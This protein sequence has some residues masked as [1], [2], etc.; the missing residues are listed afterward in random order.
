MRLPATNMKDN[1]KIGYV[2]SGGPSPTLGCNIGMGYIDLENKY[3]TSLN[4]N[5]ITIG[6]DIQIMIRNKLYSAKVVK[7]PFVEKKVKMT[8][9]SKA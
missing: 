4:N 9:R 1:H 5:D 3:F 8:N 6:M 7:R 2:T